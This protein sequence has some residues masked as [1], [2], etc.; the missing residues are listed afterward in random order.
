MFDFIMP[1]STILLSVAVFRGFIRQYFVDMFHSFGF[2]FG[3][4]VNKRCLIAS[5]YSENM[6]KVVL[7]Y[8]VVLIRMFLRVWTAVIHSNIYV[9][10][11]NGECCESW[12]FKFLRVSSLDF[13]ILIR[14]KFIYFQLVKNYFV[15]S[16][17]TTLTPRWHI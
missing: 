10:V 2:S 7:V 15:H 4:T 3:F 14:K 8:F 9:G 12:T 11:W 13:Y 17:T 16:F 6:L 5:S 1:K